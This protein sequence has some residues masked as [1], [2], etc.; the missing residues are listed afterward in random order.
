MGGGGGRASEVIAYFCHEKERKKGGWW[1]RGASCLMKT[2]GLMLR[3]N[4][5]KEKGPNSTL[6]GPAMERG[7]CLGSIVLIHLI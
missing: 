2:M 1:E 4:E 3:S 7:L 5:S 6:L